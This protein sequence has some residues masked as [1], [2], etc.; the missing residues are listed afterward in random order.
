MSKEY[1]LETIHEFFDDLD[2]RL[3]PSIS[4]MMVWAGYERDNQKRKTEGEIEE[5]F[6]GYPGY[7]YVATLITEDIAIVEEM[8][9]NETV[10]FLPCV[11]KKKSHC[12]YPT[13][14]EALLAA[15]SIKY[16]GNEN[17]AEWMWKMLK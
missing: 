2:N 16:V 8:K 3:N 15:L 12:I 5:L 10:G 13:F 1:T 14:D 17:A 11:N 9:R 7:R 6:S 4:K